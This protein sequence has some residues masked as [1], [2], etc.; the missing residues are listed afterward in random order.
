MKVSRRYTVPAL[1]NDNTALHLVHLLLPRDG[2]EG[3]DAEER[4]RDR[5]E[6]MLDA[7]RRDLDMRPSRCV[8]GAAAR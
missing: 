1:V 6:K 7:V 4:A 5:F 3:H 2:R 8:I